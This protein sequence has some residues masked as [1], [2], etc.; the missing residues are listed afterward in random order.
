MGSIAG[1]VVP[2]VLVVFSVTHQEE[3]RHK[4]ELTFATGLLVLSLLGCL[5]S[6]FA[7]AAIAGE[8]K[9]TANLPAA[10]MLVGIGTIVSVASILGAFVCFAHIYISTAVGFFLA[11][12]AGGGITGGIFNAFAVVDDWEIRRSEEMP[13]SRWLVSR[14]KA[15]EYATAFAILSTIPMAL[16]LGLALLGLHVTLSTREVTWFIAAGIVIVIVAIIGGVIRTI[17]PTTGE[18]DKGVEPVEVWVAQ[19][20]TGLYV[21][22]MLIFLPQ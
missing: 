7:F 17:H 20:V 1:F 2:S 11:I 12:T 5:A 19:L 18:H 14:K 21:G 16:G 22:A 8:K 9:L 13:L 6:A 10:A 3:A 4:M 15:T